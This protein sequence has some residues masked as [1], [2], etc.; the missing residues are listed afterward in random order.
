MEKNKN[1]Y[2]CGTLLLSVIALQGMYLF[3]QLDSCF[4]HIFTSYNEEESIERCQVQS[5]FNV[6]G[7]GSFMEICSIFHRSLS[8]KAFAITFHYMAIDISLLQ[9]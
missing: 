8:R 7:R 2:R 4:E 5:A 3:C 1:Q 9:S 6:G